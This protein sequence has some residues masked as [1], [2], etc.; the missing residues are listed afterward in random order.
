MTATRALHL[1]QALGTNDFRLV[2][3][4]TLLFFMLAYPLAW[5]LALRWG[6]QPFTNWL[7]PTFD[8]EPYYALMASGFLLLMPPLI[9]GFV[10]GFLL[11]DE[12]DDRMLS[13]LQVTPLP[14]TGYLAYRCLAPI[15][16]G[17]VMIRIIVPLANMVQ[18][19][20]LALT[21]IAVVAA[22]EGAAAALFVAVAA[23]NKVEGFALVKA[24]WALPMAA[25][26]A[27]FVESKWQLAF[28]VVPMYWPSKAFWI[29]VEG[30]E[31]FWAYLVVGLLVHLGLLWL[32]VRRFQRL[33]L[34]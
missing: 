1:L 33:V 3:R 25:M 6:A 5:A 26:V 11:L 23:N 13:A 20:F 7:R 16:L 9:F 8:L 15:V 10:I 12:R 31:G 2:R 17:I 24:L 14:L 18:I 21:A 19:S 28:G 30:G 4:Q 22:I 27:Y 29:A 32:C 34:T